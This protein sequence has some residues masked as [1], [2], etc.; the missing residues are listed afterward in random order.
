MSYFLAG[1]D[2]YRLLFPCSHSKPLDG[3]RRQG[4]IDK[5]IRR[6]NRTTKDIK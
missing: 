2:E 6:R 3:A 1:F 4:Q 5:G